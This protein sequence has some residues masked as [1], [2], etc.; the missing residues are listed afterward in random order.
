M[1]E[2]EKALTEVSDYKELC[3]DVIGDIYNNELADMANR[4]EIIVSLP[5]VTSIVPYVNNLEG[6][7]ICN[8]RNLR[9]GIDH[10]LFGKKRNKGKKK[11]DVHV[12]KYANAKKH[13]TPVVYPLMDYIT[14]DN[15]KKEIALALS[16]VKDLKMLCIKVI[17]DV[18][19]TELAERE[20][21]RDIIVSKRFLESLLPYMNSF[22]G[23]LTIK[24]VNEAIR[25]YVLPWNNESNIG[26]GIPNKMQDG[27]A[28]SAKEEKT[29]KKSKSLPLMDY[30]TDESRKAEIMLALSEVKDLK[31]LCRKV[32]LD[33]YE[34]ELSGFENRD[35]IIVS[36]PFI[37]SLFPFLKSF[38]GVCSYSNFCS[39]M[40]RYMLFWNDGRP[41][42]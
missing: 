41:W 34:T 6:S 13:K 12:A 1:A 29:V 20:D 37:E 17:Y 27:D 16:K 10:Y 7:R 25:K 42:R 3:V 24:Y 4:N 15:R 26:K 36:K 30:I 39:A 40:R 14:D 28:K 35:K 9:R 2:I 33:V 8:V 38:N 32:I 18:Y 23:K 11:A 31:A 19:E 5:F 21:R 22:Q